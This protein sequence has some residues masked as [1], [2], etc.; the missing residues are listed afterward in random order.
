VYSLIQISGFKICVSIHP[1]KVR[2]LSAHCFGC[3]TFSNLQVVSFLFFGVVF[4]DTPCHT[5]KKKGETCRLELYSWIVFVNHSPVDWSCIREYASPQP[6]WCR[7]I[8]TPAW[9]VC[10]WREWFTRVPWIIH[11][12]GIDL[13]IY[14]FI[15][16]IWRIHMWLCRLLIA[17]PAWRVCVWCEWFTCVPWMIHMYEKWLVDILIHMWNMTYPYMA[18][19]SDHQTSLVCVCV[20][21]CDVN[22]SHVCHEW[23]I[24]VRNDLLIYSF[25]CVIWR[26]HTWL[27]RLLIA[28]PAWCVSVCVCDMCGCN[29]SHIRMWDMTH[30]H[31]WHDMG[32][33][34]LVGS[35][36]LHVSFA[37]EPYKRDYILQKR[38]IILRSLLMIATPYHNLGCVVGS[39]D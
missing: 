14:S 26:I 1:E 22:D 10:V 32:W 6:R 17:R 28:R 39:L 30:S 7:P 23:I 8:A 25:I 3:K 20:C 27:C 21:V 38:P 9:C 13:L 36:K 29:M 18:V 33:L 37:K 4:M 5:Q 34:Q 16:V 19:S 15:C 24:Y 31:V 2:F 11:I 12:Y 35:F